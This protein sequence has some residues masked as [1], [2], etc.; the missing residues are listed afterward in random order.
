MTK[1]KTGDKIRQVAAEL[2]H[3]YGFEKTSM[4]DIAHLAHKAKRSIYYHFGNKEELYCTSVRQELENIQSQLQLVVQDDTQ[5]VLPRLKQYLLLRVELMA[6][7]KAVIAAMKDRQL[8]ASTYRFEELGRIYNSFAAW[9]HTLFRNVWFAKP[10][11]EP[12]TV[13]EQ[14]ATAFADM[15]QI[16]LNGLTHSFFVEGKYEEYKNSYALLVNLIVNSIFQNFTQLYQ[17]QNQQ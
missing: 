3:K 15:L 6:D 14:Q 13:V 8:T 17:N 1:L 11:D 12:E 4:D 5:K 9:E 10:T 16:T 2:F 7:A